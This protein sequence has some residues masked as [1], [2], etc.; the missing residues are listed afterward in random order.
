[1]QDMRNWYLA[2]GQ[3]QEGTSHLSRL[4]GLFVVFETRLPAVVV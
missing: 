4:T 3:G 1:M 2:V